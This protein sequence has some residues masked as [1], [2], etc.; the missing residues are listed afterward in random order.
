[1]TKT[2]HP[3]K[4][5]SLNNGQRPM[6]QSVRYS[7]SPLYI[8]MHVLIVLYSAAGYRMS[9]A[10]WTALL[11]PHPLTKVVTSLNITDTNFVDRHADWS[12]ARHWSSW[13]TNDRHLKMLCLPFSDVT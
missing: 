11:S 13:W 10:L 1:M 12:A 8:Y 9:M 3:N 5:H 4:G 2:K 6:Y 7:E